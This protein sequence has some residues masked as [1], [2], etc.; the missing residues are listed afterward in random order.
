MQ[1]KSRTNAEHNI[2]RRVTSLLSLLDRRASRRA[3]QGVAVL[4]WAFLAVL[5]SGCADTLG[6][7]QRI[8]GTW[9]RLHTQANT[10]VPEQKPKIICDDFC[11]SYKER[12]L[13]K[14]KKQHNLFPLSGF[15][16]SKGA[17][18]LT[19]TFS[20]IHQLTK[21]GQASDGT[22]LLD[23]K[24]LDIFMQELAAKNWQGGVPEPSHTLLNTLLKW[25]KNL[26]QRVL[27]MWADFG[28]YMA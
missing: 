17:A 26:R 6:S 24:M 3:I 10:Q 12:L 18:P 15:W 22:I 19:I 13:D 4:L 2:E 23:Q 8:M 21:P 11:R 27:K 16:N 1:N 20:Q 28:A 25:N 14:E 9:S 5:G 7:A